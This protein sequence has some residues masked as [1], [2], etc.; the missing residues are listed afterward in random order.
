MTTASASQTLSDPHRTE[1]AAR[2]DLR[3]VAMGGAVTGFAVALAM[4]CVWFLTHL[5]GLGVSSATAGVLQLLTLAIGVLVA[6]PAIART[7]DRCMLAGAAAGLVAGLLQLLIMGSR[8]TQQPEGAVN[9]TA[10]GVSGDVGVLAPSAGLIAGGFIATCLAVGVVAGLGS[11][12]LRL[13]PIIS[14][15]HLDTPASRRASLAFI[16]ALAIAPLLLLGGLVTSTES[17]MAVPDWPGTYGANMFLYPIGLMAHPRIFL[18]HTHRLFGSLA[19]LNALAVLLVTLLAPASRRGEGLRS[20]AVLLAVLAALGGALIAE[21]SGRL[22]TPMLL[23]LGGMMFI[24]AVVVGWIG[25]ISGRVKWA[26]AA[27]FALVANQGMLGGVRVTANDAWLAMAHGIGGQVVFA[28]SIALAAAMLPASSSGRNTRAGVFGL[29]A[30]GVLLIQLAM[31]AAYRHLGDTHA[32]WGHVVFSIV[33]VI[34]SVLAGV[35]FL[36]HALTRRLGQAIVAVV[37]LQFVLGWGALFSVMGTEDRGPSP[38][39]EQLAE[40]APP[41]APP[42]GVATGHQANGAL[43]LGLIAFGAMRTLRS[44]NAD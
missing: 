29:V 30:L 31:G 17:G 16:A 5:P 6:T 38:T 8:L 39:Y 27:V 4:W 9:P 28:T 10:I 11:W 19:G 40:A 22:A 14:T 23:V 20:F 7:L 42:G 44:P 12:G 35:W 41:P 33:A 15:R 1:R 18:E 34:A 36:K 37:G 25:A 43:L 32:L 26:A 13:A 21:Q 3:S 24:G 2:A